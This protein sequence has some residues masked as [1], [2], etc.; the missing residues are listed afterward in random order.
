MSVQA[1]YVC[2]CVACMSNTCAAC[3]WH[4]QWA[5]ACVYTCVA[6][7]YMSVHGTCMSVHEWCAC[8]ARA[9]AGL[10]LLWMEA[11]RWTFATARSKFRQRGLRRGWKLGVWPQNKCFQK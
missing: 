6:C 1:R 7:V 5:C 9:C 2:V 11:R 4:M 3:V 8:V 10:Q